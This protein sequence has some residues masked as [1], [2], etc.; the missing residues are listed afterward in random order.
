MV[1]LYVRALLT[2]PTAAKDEREGLPQ[3]TMSWTLL[4]APVVFWMF[5]HSVVLL[6]TA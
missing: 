2:I 5:W 1:Q 6:E 3:M 4:T